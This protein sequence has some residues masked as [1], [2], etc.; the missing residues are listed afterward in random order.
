[1]LLFNPRQRIICFGTNQGK[2]SQVLQHIRLLILDLD[3]LVFDCA[4]LKDQA[5]KQS[6]AALRGTISAG[7][8]LPS[9]RI[10]VEEGFRDH[11]FRWTRHLDIGLSEEG[12]SHLQ[13]AYGI[14]ENRLVNSG[15]GKIHQGIKEFIM[16]CRQSRLAV[17]LGADA[18]RDYMCA[19]IERHQLDSLFQFALCTEEFGA[20]NAIE[21]L[22]EIMHQAEVNPSETLALGTR[23]HFFEA[24]RHLD[25]LA[26]GCGWGLS[27]HD[28]LADSDLQSLSLKQV[29]PAIERADV[30]AFQRSR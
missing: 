8:Q 13:Q 22:G 15:I 9:D 21:M 17:A 20:G 1:M 4:F 23:P 2:I 24:A 30:L 14:L 5:L 27:S 19:V 25:V 18:A 28:G 10:N 6:L 7:V 12:L 26:I 29:I 16:T 11:G 3:Y